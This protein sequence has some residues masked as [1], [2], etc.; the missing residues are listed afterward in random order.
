MLEI[1]TDPAVTVCNACGKTYQTVA[2]GKICP[3]CASPDTVLLH[4]N[5]MEILEVEAW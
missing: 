5:Q 3:H 2:Y 1:R 4:G